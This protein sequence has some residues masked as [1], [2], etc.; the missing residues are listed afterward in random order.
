MIRLFV[1]LFALLPSPV[2]AT[3]HCVLLIHGLGRTPFSLAPM[4]VLLEARGYTVVNV[5]YASRQAP[6]EELAAEVLPPAYRECGPRRI[7]AITHSMGG[8]VFRAGMTQTR[9]PFLGRVVMLAPP[10]Q[11]S[12][13]VD[14][15]GEIEVFGWVGGPAGVQLGTGPDSLPLRLPPVDYPVGVIAG[16]QTIN[17]Y[18]SSVVDGPDDGKIAVSETVVEGMRAQ[19]ILPVTHTFMMNNPQVIAQALSFI[20]TGAFARHLTWFDAVGDLAMRRLLP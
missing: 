17:P 9:P 4:Q 5:G 8:I 10:N 1:I 13:L 15:L 7:H 14:M 2:F 16:S 6:V 18:F 3:G 19:L 20:E 11:G 12:Q